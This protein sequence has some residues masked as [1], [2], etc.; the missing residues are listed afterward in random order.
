MDQ[1]GAMQPASHV[2]YQIGK[3]SLVEI[4]IPVQRLRPIGRR[5]NAILEWNFLLGTGKIRIV[6]HLFFIFLVV[7]FDIVPVV[8]VRDLFSEIKMLRWSRPIGH[9]CTCNIGSTSGLTTARGYAK[10]P[11]LPGSRV[12]TEEPLLRFGLGCSAIRY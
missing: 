9:R 5:P 10:I 6:D 3:C 2:K 8:E 12:L 1:A 11:V 7:R 4:F